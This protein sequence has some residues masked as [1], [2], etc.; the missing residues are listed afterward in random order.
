MYD[1]GRL[2]CSNACV[3]L[4]A[5]GTSRAGDVDRLWRE[6]FLLAFCY[7]AHRRVS[8]EETKEQGR[9]VGSGIWLCFFSP[10]R[11]VLC[12]DFSYLLLP[13]VIPPSIS[14]LDSRGLEG[15]VGGDTTHYVLLAVLNGRQVSF[16]SRPNH[17]THFRNLN[18]CDPALTEQPDIASIFAC[19][20]AS[21]GSV[22][23][24]GA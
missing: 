18:H 1:L 24:V 9:P 22:S 12:L 14:R 23:G 4:E 5:H 17:T 20:T 21:K 2:E 19:R 3:D 15:G 10:S 6:A 13:F 8:T 11:T 7:L 16:R